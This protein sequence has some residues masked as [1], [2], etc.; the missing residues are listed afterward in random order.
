MQTTNKQTNKNTTIRFDPFLQSSEKSKTKKQTK[1]QTKKITK[2]ET[3]K[4]IKK[5]R[6]ENRNKK[7]PELF[8]LFAPPVFTRASNTQATH[9]NNKQRAL[10]PATFCACLLLFFACAEDTPGVSI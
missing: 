9:A 5:Q 4:Q 1:K 2:T 10:V 7:S 6:I 3:E 8:D